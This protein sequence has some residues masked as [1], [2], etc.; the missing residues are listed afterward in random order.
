[1]PPLNVCVQMRL[2]SKQDEPAKSGV[3]EGQLPAL[4]DLLAT[5]PGLQLRGLM[6]IPA[7]SQSITE[8]RAAFRHL[9]ECFAAMQTRHPAMDTLSMG[10]SGDFD[11]AIAEGAT[12]VRLGTALF[13]PRVGQ[14][15]G[16]K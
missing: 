5:L 4:C 15:G 16:Q 14:K 11:A 1:M 8:Q 2:S 13:G 6:G 10:M 9:A 3:S 7:A 12:L